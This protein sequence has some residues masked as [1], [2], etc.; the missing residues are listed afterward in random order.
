MKIII[1]R[2]VDYDARLLFVDA[3]VRYWDDASV[4]GVEDK[5]GK[6]IPCRDGDSWRL[7][8]DLETGKIIRWEIGKEADIHYKVY[9]AGSYAL[10][11]DAGDIIIK[12]DGY[13]PD[14]LCPKEEGY[15]DYIIMD[16]DKNGIIKN[17]KP[18]LDYFMDKENEE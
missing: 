3:E 15:G 14:M 4:N 7:A 13:V 8:I 5:E 1:K 6:L 10:L 16:V 11:D 12:K 18:S 2:P 17:W 9:D